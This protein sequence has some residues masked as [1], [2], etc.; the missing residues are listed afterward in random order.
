MGRSYIILKFKENMFEDSVKF[1]KFNKRKE[2]CCILLFPNFSFLACFSL[3]VATLSLFPCGCIKLSHLI[4][5][6]RDSTVTFR[7][8]EKSFPKVFPLE[9]SGKHESLVELLRHFKAL[10]SSRERES[11]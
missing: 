10:D 6:H 4:L 11:L 9:F 8:S 5:C 1:P 3:T 2:E 7:K